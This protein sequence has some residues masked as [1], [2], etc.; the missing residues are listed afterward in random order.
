MRNL[1]Y[2]KS[3][4]P[5]HFP[6]DLSEEE[7]VEWL[8]IATPNALDIAKRACTEFYGPEVHA[9]VIAEI[10]RKSRE[11]SDR[12]TL[13]AIG[14]SAPAPWYRDR[15]FLLGAAS[16]GVTCLLGVSTLFLGRCTFGG[17]I[18]YPEPSANE[19]GNR[20]SQASPADS[21][22]DHSKDKHANG[23]GNN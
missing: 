13:E 16:M 17:L 10:D 11:E 22:D 21:P 7:Q 5:R 12:K 4:H 3:I 23:T 8:R 18:S 19:D 2:L 15:N 20:D 1:E 9:R 14:R 6:S